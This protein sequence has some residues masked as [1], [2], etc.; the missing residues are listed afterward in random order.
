V[1]QKRSAVLSAFVV[2][3]STVVMTPR[4]CAQVKLEVMPFFASYYATNYTTYKSK[5]E[6]ERQEAGPGLG[7]TA[8]YHFN[9]LVGL[10]GSATYVRSGIVPRQ[11]QVAGTINI[12]TPL[13]GALTFASARLT[14][15]PRRSNYF[16]SL[17]PGIVHR[18]GEAWQIP[19]YDLTSVAAVAGFG[20]RARIT[21]EWEF[22][23]GIDGNFYMTDPDGQQ[24]YYQRRM[25][26]DV[27]LSIG[28]PYAL[29]GR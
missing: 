23:I 22:N 7:V 27:L 12:L 15:Q 11:P 26:R 10:Q 5:D 2:T 29:M 21:P 19:G 25:Q 28:V 17:G 24:Q 9:R 6:N 18:S 4:L 20:I 14:L 3:L 16:L 13:R 8:A 1:H